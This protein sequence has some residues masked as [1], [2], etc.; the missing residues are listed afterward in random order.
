MRGRLRALRFSPNGA[1]ILLQDETTAYVIQT[2]PL[3][4]VS[5]FA[6]NSMLPIRFSADSQSVVGAT[7]DMTIERSGTGEDK[8]ADVRSLGGG[9]V[10]HAATLS[11][12]GELYA[13]L[14]D[15]SDVRVFQTR[16][17]EQIFQ[18]HIGE[19]IPPR[20]IFP[21]PLHLGLARS[22]PF[23]YYLAS[24]PT[25]PNDPMRSA[26]V[27]QFSLE[28]RFL[29]A[30]GVYSTSATLIDLQRRAPADVPKMMKHAIDQGSTTFVA[31]DRVVASD[32]NKKLDTELLSFP[33]GAAI[34]KL[35]LGGSFAP[36]SNPHYAI[37]TPEGSHESSVIDLQTG[38]SVASLGE[39]GGD[40]WGTEALSETNDGVLTLTHIGEA[41]PVLRAL[42]P[43]SSLSALRVAAVTPD[44]GAIAIGVI[45]QAGVY[46]SATGK[47]TA[48]FDALRGAWFADDQNC[49]VLIP[50]ASQKAPATIERIDSR[51]GATSNT[52]SLDD[53]TFRNEHIFSGPVL[54]SHY[55]KEPVFLPGMQEF[56]FELQAIDPSNAR[57]LWTRSFDISPGSQYRYTPVPFTDPQGDRVVLGW[58]AKAP[59]GQAAANRDATTKRLVKSEKLSEHDS[60]FE[61]LD[62]R[63]GRMAGAALVQTG[64]EAASFD[65]AFS[66]G[67]WLVLEKNGRS[68]MVFS[69]S[70]GEQ[71]VQETG[72]APAISAASGLLSITTDGG[73]LELYDLKARAKKFG[74]DFPQEIAY[75]HFSTDGKRLLVLTEDQTVYVL[76][77]TKIPATPAPQP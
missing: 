66:E 73:R 68:A 45:G 56:P 4:V 74:Y 8:P 38:K 25:T 6:S 75:S 49:Y 64:A 77:L 15:K 46:E 50:G 62:T 65:S 22:E 26:G 9:G 57:P 17:G 51:S 12:D 10:C 33:S 47:R 7:W 37:N 53:T 35:D 29:A 3:A 18:G 58:R 61:V 67:D 39:R 70:T 16:T 36:T 31:P 23:G 55:I 63:T 14:D 27:L 19:P 43:V 44:L 5:T 72:Y 60:L 76:D 59:G 52:L 11:L 1:Y 24:G 2:N 48:E 71:V 34:S 21:T 41:Q 28:G 20:V 40:V 30:R 13:C 42:T 54:L 32:P 69:L